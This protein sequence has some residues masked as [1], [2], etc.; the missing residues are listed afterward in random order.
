MPEPDQLQLDLD[1]GQL[2]LD[3]DGGIELR[4][5]GMARAAQSRQEMLEIARAVA[6][7]IAREQGGVKALIIMI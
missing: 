2:Q 4:E 7:E 5:I 6:E 3:L 1:G